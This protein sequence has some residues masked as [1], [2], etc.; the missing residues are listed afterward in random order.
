MWKLAGTSTL[1][2]GVVPLLFLYTDNSNWINISMLSW[3]LQNIVA[4]TIS[5][6]E[7]DETE[8][9]IEFK[10]WVQWNPK[11]QAAIWKNMKYFFFFESMH[12]MF[13]WTHSIGPGNDLVPNKRRAITGI[14]DDTN[15]LNDFFWC[16]R[17]HQ[18]LL[19]FVWGTSGQY[20][21][22]PQ[23]LGELFVSNFVS[24]KIPVF[25]IKHY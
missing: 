23:L 25:D 6:L 9:A 13:C 16:L 11:K 7:W 3:L 22:G 15:I 12:C 18:F 14:D 24:Q 5:E 19:P 10:L 8:F 21:L 1:R 2:A 20:Q 17:K 4:A